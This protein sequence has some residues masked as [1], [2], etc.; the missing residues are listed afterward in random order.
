[1]STG[2]GKAGVSGS[3]QTDNPNAKVLQA[4]TNGGAHTRPIAGTG[5]QNR[6]RYLVLSGTP[7]TIGKATWES[8]SNIT[9]LTFFATYPVG[10]T[11]AYDEYVLV[12]IDSVSDAAGANNLLQAT[13]ETAAVQ[14]FPIPMNKMI[15]IPLSA[16]M[17]NGT[18]SAGVVHARTS[19][20]IALDLWI[21]A[22]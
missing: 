18:N 7:T 2:T 10:A 14:W 1:M 5:A 9:D 21:G 17:S 15:S 8:D 20:G 4:Y 22:S 19:G 6:N 12:T 11:I 3:Q 13:S 16:A